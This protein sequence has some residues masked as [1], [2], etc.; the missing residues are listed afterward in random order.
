[1]CTIETEW[2]LYIV[3][4]TN[5]HLFLKELMNKAVIMHASWG[6]NYHHCL[7]LQVETILSNLIAT[8]QQWHLDLISMYFTQVV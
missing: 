5:P 8:K 7:T 2:I 6:R 3:P 1:M 4:Q